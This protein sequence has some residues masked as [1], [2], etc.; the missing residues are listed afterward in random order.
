[1]KEALK[2]HRKVWTGGQLRLHC[3]TKGIPPPKVKWLKDGKPVDSSK[4]HLRRIKIGNETITSLEIFTVTCQNHGVY[5]CLADGIKQCP[6]VVKVFH[7]N[8]MKRRAAVPC[9]TKQKPKEKQEMT[10]TNFE[11]FWMKY[12]NL[13]RDYDFWRF[14]YDLKLFTK[15]SCY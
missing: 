1:M 7:I 10:R 2:V 3:R 11:K 8:V 5:S 6:V 13:H 4:T 14:C 12:Y 9:K 15:H